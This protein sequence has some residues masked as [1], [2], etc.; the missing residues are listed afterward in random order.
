MAL[1]LIR[2]KKYS[3]IVDIDKAQTAKSNIIIG[4]YTPFQCR[5]SF[6]KKGKRIFLYDLLW[7]DIPLQVCEKV[8]VIEYRNLNQIEQNIVKNIQKKIPL[9]REQ[10]TYLKDNFLI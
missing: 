1:K 6:D 8:D 10:H 9:N 3:F 5:K 4:N 7:S 2:T